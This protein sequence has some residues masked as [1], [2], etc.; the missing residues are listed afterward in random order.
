MKGEGEMN[1]IEET[2]KHAPFLKGKLWRKQIESIQKR[3]ESDSE[4]LVATCFSSDGMQQLYVTTKRVYFN[5]IKGTFSNNEQTIMLSSISNVQ[6]TSNGLNA[7]LVI[8]ASNALLKIEKVSVGIAQTVAKEIDRLR[9]TNAAPVA[10][11][12]KDTFDLADEIRELKDL[13]D[14][15]LLTQEEFDAKK[16]QLLGV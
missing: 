9:I 12:V 1:T 8:T 4:K 14:E 2:I 5:E 10:A 3:L 15:G 11:P 16:K 7:D 13:L 6:C